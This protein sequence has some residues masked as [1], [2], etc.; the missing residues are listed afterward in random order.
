MRRPVIAVVGAGTA[1]EA[2]AEAAR[3]VGS[4]IAK[5]GAVL[6]SGGLGGVMEAAAQGAKEAG[7]VTLG[8]LPGADTWSA[9]PH[10]DHPIATNMGQA[11]NAVIVQTADA[12]VSVHGGYGTLS[13]I[14]LALKAAK[15]VF[16][17][18][19]PCEVP[20]ARIVESPEEAVERAVAAARKRMASS[21]GKGV[22]R[23]G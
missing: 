22:E 23:D 13:E 19:P 4:A 7:G 8:I 14:A 6:I 1:S 18:H 5:A 9:N 12:V 16:C 11:R 17:I 21:R 10:I 15:P 2:A 20:G 3:R